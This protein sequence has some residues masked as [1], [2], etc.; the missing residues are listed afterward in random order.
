MKSN[1]CISTFLLIAL[2]GFIE[3]SCKKAETPVVPVVPSIVS[4]SPLSGKSGDTI[5]I[6][7]TNFNSNILGNS[8]LVN[9]VDASV[10]F[11]NTTS[12]KFIVPNIN[13]S[14]QII[15]TTGGQKINGPTFTILFPPTITSVTPKTGRK[16]DTITIAGTNFGID[17]ASNKLTMNGVASIIV[18]ASS[19]IVKALVPNMQTS[20]AVQLT[21]VV[22]TANGGNF[23]YI[24]PPAPTITS[25]SPLRITQGDTVTISGTNFSTSISGDSTTINGNKINLISAKSTSLQFVFNGITTQSGDYPFTLQVSTGGGTGSLQKTFSVYNDIYTAGYGRLNLSSGGPL[26][27]KYFKN[28]I[29]TNLTNGITD[30]VAYGISVFGNDVY[31]VGTEKN[32][33]GIFVAKYWKNGVANNLTDGKQNSFATSISFSQNGDSHIVGV[34]VDSVNILYWKNGTRMSLNSISLTNISSTICTAPSLFIS[35]NNDVFIQGDNGYLKNGNFIPYPNNNLQFGGSIYVTANNDV[36][37]ACAKKRNVTNFNTGLKEA[38]SYGSV[39]LKN[40][41][42]IYNDEDPFYSDLSSIVVDE[43]NNYYACGR[44]SSGFIRACTIINGTKNVIDNYFWEDGLGGKQG[45]SAISKE[46]NNLYIIGGMGFIYKNNVRTVVPNTL[47]LTSLFI[48]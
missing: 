9:G 8:V 12:I 31:V 30:A 32:A 4:V 6:I 2:L 10:I 20:G 3:V 44:L 29:E 47:Q 24:I 45:A 38:A 26:V 27:A 25:I 28:E 7:G 23:T 34:N 17:I 18:L 40:N 36:Y 22:G 1:L 37:L 15:L 39:I 43:N 42:V 41:I 11:S 35:K 19:S 33:N 21:T 48:K 46:G 14:G 13:S 16:G 5:T